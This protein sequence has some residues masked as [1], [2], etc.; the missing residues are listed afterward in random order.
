[1]VGVPEEKV[2]EI[3]REE[4]Q[5]RSKY[6]I[7]EHGWLPGLFRTIIQKA[8]SILELL[9]R[10]AKLPPKPKPGIDMAVFKEM[11][12]L[13]HRLRK[14]ASE[15][16]QIQDTKLP[17]LRA[18]LSEITGI[19]KGK[20]RKAKEAE[21]EATEKKVSDLKDRISRMVREYGYPDGQAFMA[22][23]NKAERI[24]K[25]YEWELAE[26]K[27]QVEENQ[28]K[29]RSRRSAEALWHS[30]TEYGT[31]HRSLQSV[32]TETGTNDKTTDTNTASFG[33]AYIEQQPGICVPGC[34]I[35]LL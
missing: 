16:K 9:I 3:K 8:K 10:Q 14:C 20:E 7:S 34:L 33:G 31:R 35:L 30:F 24:V 12:E 22:A 32:P 25:Q 19:F 29:K 4:I 1:M 26:W 6:S 17:E 5:N 2:L 18:Q 28:P 11:K 15:I 21:I 13:L 23:Y 27:Q